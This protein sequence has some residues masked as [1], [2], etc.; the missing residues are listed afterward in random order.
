MKM[1]DE[2]LDARELMCPMPMVKLTKA[3]RRRVPGQELEM[4]SDDPGSVEDVPA[5]SSG[6]GNELIGTATDDE[7][8]HFIIRK[9]E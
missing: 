7:G 9:G 4:L 2:T 1:V 8:Y 5:W 6:T 3:M